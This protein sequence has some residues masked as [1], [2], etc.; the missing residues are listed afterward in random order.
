MSS[1]V[2][3]NHPSADGFL[4]DVLDGLR[5]PRKSLPCKY[6]YDARGSQLFERICTLAEYYPTRTELGIM[7][8]RV[9]QMADSLGAS[10]RLVELGAGSGL[11]TELLLG[12]LDQPAAYL[13]VEISESAL[14]GCARKLGKAYPDLEILPVCADYTGRVDLPEPTTPFAATAAYFPGSTIGNFKPAQAARFLGRIARMVGDGGGLLIGVDLQKER[15]VLQAAYN[16]RRGVTAAFNL[17]MLERINRELGA[18][19]NL[20]GFYHRAVFNDDDGRIEMH[21]VSSRAQTVRVGQASV[22]F[23]EG[24]FI[25]TE[26]SYKY[27]TAGFEALAE[28][29]GFAVRRLWTDDQRWFSVWYL[30]AARG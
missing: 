25:T 22:A 17:N 21:L 7:E 1:A 30:E 13:P 2:E 16:D 26:Y 3:S 14:D 29:A 10:V 27:T 20:D 9:G 28:E 8:Q 11:K 12:A 23:D 6:F 24:E 18:D 5:G 4:S 19:F 15:A